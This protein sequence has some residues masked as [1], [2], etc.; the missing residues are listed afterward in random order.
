MLEI[1]RIS[2]KVEI[3]EVDTSDVVPARRKRSA[4]PC[5]VSSEVLPDIKNAKKQVA[6]IFKISSKRYIQMGLLNAAEES[7]SC[8]I[9]KVCLPKPH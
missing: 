6:K 7:F 5:P 8:T 1:L 4:L 3:E 2:R 9:C